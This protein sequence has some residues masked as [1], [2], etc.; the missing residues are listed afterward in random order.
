M[1]AHQHWR[2]YVTANNGGSYTS[3][4][5]M[6]LRESA[7]GINRCTGG[8]VVASSQDTGWWDASNLVDGG[9]GF[10]QCWSTTSAGKV[11]AYFGYSFADGTSWDIQHLTLKFCG[12]ESYAGTNEAP[13][14]FSLQY[15]D[16]G[17]GWITLFSYTGQTWVASEVKTFGGSEDYLGSGDATY[18]ITASGTG[19]FSLSYLGSGAADYQFSAAGE[20]NFS[21][22]Y[23]ASG[24][25][26]YLIA[27]SGTG[28]YLVTGVGTASHA[29]DASGTG[30][31][32][33]L[34]SGDAIYAGPSATGAGVWTLFPRLADFM[35]IRY[36][37]TAR[38]PGFDDYPLQL[39]TLQIIKRASAP[40]YYSLSTPLDDATADALHART[41]ETIRILSHTERPDGSRTQ[42]VE[43]DWF[44]VDDLRASRGPT[45][46][47]LN[48]SGTRRDALSSIVT[49]PLTDAD[50]TQYGINSDGS[51]SFDLI[52]AYAYLTPAS[53]LRYQGQDYR[54]N[55]VQLS[56]SPG[57]ASVSA[58]CD[59]I[60]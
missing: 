35:A 29:W 43:Y 24:D 42:P 25:A 49:L 20:G 12:A 36:S 53:T 2:V 26:L 4:G 11:P 14:S 17:L 27:A 15:Y 47:T 58:R 45:S 60:L 59:L 50:L 46:G 37:A 34:G 18:Q 19:E 1:A 3:M 55:Y 10:G 40:S 57:L 9:V 39:K 31:Q 33:P 56:V 30:G 44:N 48:I 6:E 32:I 28:Y 51:A 54:I 5:E 7:G 22:N 21:A 13:A 23:S 16:D 8:S 41:V 38:A 52:P